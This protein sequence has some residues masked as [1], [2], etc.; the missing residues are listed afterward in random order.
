V[1]DNY[2]LSKDFETKITFSPNGFTIGGENSAEIP[3]SQVI[4][5]EED[6]Q[7]TTDNSGNYLFRKVASSVKNT[8]IKVGSSD[9]ICN[10]VTSKNKYDLESICTAKSSSSSAAKRA[11]STTK[12]FDIKAIAT[13]EFVTVK[14]DTSVKALNKVATDINIT[15][16]IS[17]TDVRELTISKDFEIQLPSFYVVDDASLTNGKLT[18]TKEEMV[19]GKTTKHINIKGI[20]FHPEN[21]RE[22]ETISF[23]PKNG[24]IDLKGDVTVIG[25]ITMPGDVV[26]EVMNPGTGTNPSFNLNVTIDNAKTSS[27]TGMFSKKEALSIDPINMTNVPSFLRDDEVVIDIENPVLKLSLENEIP[28][29]LLLNGTFE[30]V[31]DNKTI[32]TVKVGN[33]NN[34]DEI[35]FAAGSANN[36]EKVKTTSKVWLSKVALDNLPEEVTNVIV[37]DLSSLITKLPDEIRIK[38]TAQTDANKESTIALA[39]SYT[40]TP[41]YELEAPIKMGKNMKIVYSKDVED[42]HDN[43]K[44]VEVASV[45][46][47]T[48]IINRLPLDLDF[49]IIPLDENGNVINDIVVEAPKTIYGTKSTGSATQQ[50]VECTLTNK[51]GKNGIGQ[52]D[53]ITVKAIG[54][55]G[56][57]L[58]GETL[59]E[60]QNLR[61]DHVKITLKGKA[62]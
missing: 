7:L 19:G 44:D 5:L 6:G 58:E 50:S 21:P 29:D 46:L 55:T 31:K 34:T 35:R 13:P 16:D 11:A 36:G 24:S 22:D 27:V 47:T 8:T 1:T 60:N 4:D 53:R 61:M 42:L 62:E 41:D 20:N 45:T 39:T 9:N 25:E 52:L 56:T 33:E 15:V 30:S 28:A 57:S 32:A 2:D 40:A 23:N 48:Y 51:E 49:E 3:L 10:A 14:Q 38:A 26:E 37:S 12:S 59:N 18:V 43:I 17:F 54:V